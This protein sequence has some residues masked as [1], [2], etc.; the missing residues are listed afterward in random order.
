[1]SDLSQVED[2]VTEYKAWFGGMSDDAMSIFCLPKEC[3]AA[4]LLEVGHPDV[5]PGRGFLIC[6]IPC[7]KPAPIKAVWVTTSKEMFLTFE[8]ND[9][10]WNTWTNI[11]YDQRRRG[12]VLLQPSPEA[13]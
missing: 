2:T 4:K 8:A 11:P 10:V 3:P 13:T 12:V 5:E 9:E 6:Y 7:D 1:M